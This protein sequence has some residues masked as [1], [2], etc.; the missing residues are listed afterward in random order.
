MNK[1]E[2]K[3]YIEA[4]LKLVEYSEFRVASEE[5]YM[6]WYGEIPG[7]AFRGV[8]AVHRNKAV[9]KRMVRKTMEHWVAVQQ[10]LGHALPDLTKVKRETRRDVPNF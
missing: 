10:Y 7:H 4:A 2:T 9:C 6:C 5:P 3:T 8:Y 1:E